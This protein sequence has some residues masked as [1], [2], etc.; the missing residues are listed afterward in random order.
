MN[1]HRDLQSHVRT[2][3][4]DAWELFET[5]ATNDFAF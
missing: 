2:Y 5:F 3:C 1:D 4:H